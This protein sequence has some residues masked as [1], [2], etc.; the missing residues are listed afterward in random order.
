MDQHR[1]SML[2]Y[3]DRGISISAFSGL[4]PLGTVYRLDVRYNGMQLLPVCRSSPWHCFE[5]FVLIFLTHD[6]RTHK[7]P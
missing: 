6:L 5:V 4:E 3:H 1:P 2:V 7:L